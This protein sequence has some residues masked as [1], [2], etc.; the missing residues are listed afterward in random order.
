MSARSNVCD[1]CEAMSVHSEQERRRS[2]PV[3]PSLSPL[4]PGPRS[5][6][7][8]RFCSRIPTPPVLQGERSLTAPS[9]EACTE[10]AAAVVSVQGCGC[11]IQQRP[12]SGRAAERLPPQSPGA[13]EQR[14]TLLS[15]VRRT[16]RSRTQERAGGTDV[17]AKGPR[18][19]PP[20]D[21]ARE[22]AAFSTAPHSNERQV[23]HMQPGA[24]SI[25]ELHLYLPSMGCESEEP[26]SDA[27]EM[28]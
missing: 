1:A 3:H 17:A 13:G 19:W 27:E 9:S 20:K 7:D 21:A 2:K 16:A 22:A 24:H 28:R 10:R 4:P 6:Q 5:Y 25:A 11:S 26:G 14:P 18:M 8:P 23:D 12:P 15:R